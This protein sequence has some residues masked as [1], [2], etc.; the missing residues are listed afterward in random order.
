MLSLFAVLIETG[1][2]ARNYC[3]LAG[4]TTPVIGDVIVGLI[5]MGI[6]LKGL[7]AYSRRMKL[8]KPVPAPQQVSVPKSLNLLQAGVRQGHPPHIPS[9]L[10][11]LPD[12]HAYI[13]TPTHKQPVTEYE[14]I[15]E[16]AASQKRDVERAL[17]KF[18]AK[19]SDTHSL[20]PD[21]KEANQMFPLIAC[22]PAFPSYLAALNPTDQVFDF[23]E[24]EYHYQVAN[25]TEDA[26]AEEFDEDDEHDESKEMD[27]KASNVC[28]ED[29]GAAGQ[30]V[31][32]TAVSASQQDNAAM[33]NNP[34]L[35]PPKVPLG[36]QR[37]D[38]PQ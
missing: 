29:D 35:R 28:S 16:K 10:P 30:A 15:R 14:A 7:E 19:T 22:K 37:A 25:R 3:E 1:Q 8:I 13:R 5:N 11:P 36:A 6:S 31:T 32:E 18:L 9:H 34:F 17:T 12:P 27:M 21:A 23:E 38:L 24:L 4:R 33:M 26:P 2:S 20:F